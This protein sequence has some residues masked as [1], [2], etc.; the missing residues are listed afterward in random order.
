[1]LSDILKEQSYYPPV[2]QN[3]TD[4]V[5]IGLLGSPD[6]AWEYSAHLSRQ[7]ATGWYKTD[8]RE[9]PMD[10]ELVELASLGTF[11]LIGK[12]QIVV[13]DSKQVFD[14]ATATLTTDYWQKD[15]RGENRLRVRVTS[16][17]TR[18][19][20][21]VEHYEILEA[22]TRGASFQFSIGPAGQP[23]VAKQPASGFTKPVIS[24][25]LFEDPEKK[26]GG[27]RYWT[28]KYEGIALT[29]TDME[30]TAAVPNWGRSR[31]YAMMRNPIAM[32]TPPVTEPCA[33]TRYSCVIDEDD[34]GEDTLN[35]RLQSTWQKT[36]NLG[37]GGILK[38]HQDFWLKYQSASTVTIPNRPDIQY[39]YEF[40]H[41]Y[42][43]TLQEEKS[44]FTPVGLQPFLWQGYHFW[45]YSFFQYAWLG[46]NYMEESARACRFLIS[47]HSDARKLARKMG[48]PGARMAWRTGRTI[49]EAYAEKD[50]QFHNNSVAAYCLYLHYCVTGDRELLEEAFPLM[51]DLVTFMV[52]TRVEDAGTHAIMR[53]CMGP[54]ESKL[55]LKRNDSWTCAI[56]ICAIEGL[57]QS[58]LEL[59][60]SPSVADLKG[61][62]EKL[63]AGLDKNV[64]AKGVMQSFQGGTVPHWGS[65]V[66]SH[67]PEHP[68]LLAT[69]DKMEEN[70]D[71]EL[72]LYN[73]HAVT[74]Y[75]EK[76]FPWTDFWTATILALAGDRRA[77]EKIEK[78]IPYANMFGGLAERIFF[79]GERFKEYTGTVHGAFCWALQTCMVNQVGDTLRLFAGVPESWGDAA[80]ENLRTQS[81]LLVSAERRE[82]KVCC[83]TVTSASDITNLFWTDGVL[84][85]QRLT[86]KKG[87]NEIPLD[88]Q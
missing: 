79:H 27:F 21:L 37:Y 61:V 74:R 73:T 71:P 44:G 31:Q 72:D 85:P 65:L 26:G 82:G 33:F 34:A 9:S 8:R 35:F 53:D 40:S 46:G 51:D 80:F 55:D 48:C 84:K 28:G 78:Q 57:L 88:F 30:G 86:L 45:D 5:L 12:D 1:M 64:D 10:P 52:E 11:P 36:V 54:D 56:T 23:E 59:G 77:G 24:W 83:L 16:F 50:V 49:F 29:W 62:A 4:S 14:A 43:K 87:I 58:A 81:G 18:D 66:F 2:L 67:L 42:I 3:G 41:Y 39:I 63:R 47:R 38:E 20:L 25:Q 7:C 22:P 60:K 76:S 32:K 68:A 15:N 6:G 70:Y 19:H 17:M 69:I 75:A 13:A